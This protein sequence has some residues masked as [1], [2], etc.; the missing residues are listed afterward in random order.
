MWRPSW[1]TQA[2]EH[3]ALCAGYI[4]KGLLGTK[5]F[6]ANKELVTEPRAAERPGPDGRRG[7]P[8]LRTFNSCLCLPAPLKPSLSVLSPKYSLLAHR[9]ATVSLLQRFRGSLYASVTN[10]TYGKDSRS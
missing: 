10:C 1:A 3:G 6:M 7:G 2:P 8:G 5:S 9:A 4:C